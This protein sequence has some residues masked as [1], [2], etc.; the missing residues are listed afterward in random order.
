MASA[1]ELL[2]QMP[3]LEGDKRIKPEEWDFMNRACDDALKSPT[4]SVKGVI[5]AFS[6]VDNGKDY[7]ARYLL[8]GIV[9]IAA[10]PENKGKL[11]EV[12]AAIAGKL[13]TVKGKEIQAALLRELR[14]AGTPSASKAIAEYAT[15]EQLCSDACN[16]LRSIKVGATALLVA[17]YPNSKGKARIEIVHA[18]AALGEAEGLATIQKA[19]DEKELD[20]RLAAAWGIAQCG[21]AT[22]ADQ[23]LKSVA[24]AADW[25]KISLTDSC[26]RLAERLA[27]SGK[28]ADAQKIYKGLAESHK[29]EGE[30]HVAEMC[31]KALS[32]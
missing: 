25:E 5:D 10:L 27:A 28:K 9:T 3:P 22:S 12:I 11:E 2:S 18:L 15:D 8:R 26:M 31:K 16:A 14:F 24:G 6:D 32:A 20:T 17:A 7:R 21:D 4:E 13:S 19:L 23:L 29:G 1:S 30:E